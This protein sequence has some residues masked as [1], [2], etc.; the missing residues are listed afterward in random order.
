MRA[1]RRRF[2][3]GRYHRY[4]ARY[5]RPEKGLFMAHTPTYR[6]TGVGTGFQK[7]SCANK[8]ALLIDATVDICVAVADGLAKDASLMR[9]A[10][11]AVLIGLNAAQPGKTGRP[12]SIQ[13]IP[14]SVLSSIPFQSLSGKY[15]INSCDEHK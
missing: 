7:R 2:R 15:R 12:P 11:R 4:N 1:L 8:N 10:R 13:R 6:G 14:L 9:A 3:N 5:V